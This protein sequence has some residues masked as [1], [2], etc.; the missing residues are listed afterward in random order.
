MSEIYLGTI[1]IEPNRWFGIDPDRWATIALTDWLDRI[2]DAGFD[3]I[4][5]WE[6]HF[7]DADPDEQMA[8]ID[9]PLAIPFANTYVS[10]DEP[11]DRDRTAAADWVRRSG[12]AKVKWNTGPERDADLSLIHI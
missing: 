6:A 7:R 3:G 4:E 1:A 10:F 11:D 8:I 9:H 2:A 5:L 12:A